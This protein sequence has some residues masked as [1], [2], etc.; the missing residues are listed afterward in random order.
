MTVT[1][2]LKP[3]RDAS[4]R[5]FHPWIF[6]G[7]IAKVDG[8]QVKGA[9]VTVLSAEGE[10]I[11]TG[12]LSQEGSIAVKVL[13]FDAEPIDATFWRRRMRAAIQRRRSLGLFD[14]Q[15]TNAFRLVHAEGDDCPGLIVDRYGSTVVL[16][17]HAEGITA[18]RQSIVEALLEELPVRPDVIY[19]KSER[20]LEAGGER[21]L[22]GEPR[23]VEIKEN[24]RRYLVDI[25]RGQKT[26]F[27]LDQR[28]NRALLGRFARGK[29]V[30]NAFSYSGGFSMYA[31]T[32][33]ALHVTSVDSSKRA[34]EL[35]EENVALNGVGDRH[36]SVTADFLAYMS[37]LERGAF[38]VIVLDPPAFAKH[39]EAI[40][41]GLKGYRSINQRALEALPSG[42]ILFTFSCSQLVRFE[43]FQ[44]TVTDALLRAGRRG[45]VLHV[46]HQ[47]ACHPVSLTHPEGRYLKGLVVAVS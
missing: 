7:A 31:L 1:V 24:A 3:G 18:E 29:K 25:E 10:R 36:L 21:Y 45:T 32:A 14:D 23:R 11:G 22:V 8:A 2:R 27:F 26:G 12:F 40:S 46:M 15:G 38:D 37:G 28:D 30:L 6:S 9:L 44:G 41:S 13:S 42:G 34:V 5:R 16:Q 33:G 47:A 17:S 4:V 35:L 19:D 20:D 43:Q 39:R